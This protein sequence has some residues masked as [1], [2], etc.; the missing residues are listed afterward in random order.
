MSSIIP[1]MT[2]NTA[3]MTKWRKLAVCNKPDNT[4]PSDE[5][6]RPV[7]STE[8]LREK[9]PPS[10]SS[11]DSQD[12]SPE[13]WSIVSGFRKDKLLW[14]GIGDISNISAHNCIE[15]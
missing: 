8:Y 9:R 5:E 10:S 3:F 2:R 1:E 11:G 12:I 6:M 7:W 4:S 14:L 13:V 15:K